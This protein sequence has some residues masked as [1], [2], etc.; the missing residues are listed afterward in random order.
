MLLKL[1][2]TQ[3]AQNW[4][5]LQWAIRQGL[6]PLAYD[7]PGRENRILEQLQR[8][9]VHAW[10]SYD[11]ADS[12]SPDAAVLT[13]FTEDKASGVRNLFVYCIAS[14]TPNAK[15]PQAAWEDGLRTLIQFARGANCH[16]LIG[17]TNS[18]SIVRFVKGVPGGECRHAFVTVDV[19]GG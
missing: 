6:P 7:S 5:S 14:F 8:D 10:L 1:L 3:I 15:I 2:P 18:K 4:P 16:R 17:L 12:E 13:M 19:N 9:E 11:K